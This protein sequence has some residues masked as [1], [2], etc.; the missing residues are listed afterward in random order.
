MLERETPGR[1]VIRV[2]EG[3]LDFVFDVASWS[4]A[5]AAT[6]AAACRGFAFAESAAEERGEEVGEGVLIAEHLLH[7]FLRHRAEAALPA[8]RVDVPLTCKRVRAARA[9]RL[10]VGAPVRAKLV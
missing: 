7:F 10:F 9:L 6:R 4:R 3:Q 5:A 2:L 8:A 1:A